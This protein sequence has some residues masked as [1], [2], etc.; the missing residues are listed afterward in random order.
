MC[1][2]TWYDVGCVLVAAVQTIDTCQAMFLPVGASA[3]LLIMFLF[4]DSLQMI[5]A[6]F[7]ASKSAGHFYRF[8]F[9][10][11]ASIKYVALHEATWCMVVWR[12]QDIYAKIAVSCGTSCASAVSAPLW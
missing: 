8:F 7:T 2:C 10:E 5:F 3:S 4:F 12:T 9:T 6:I 11:A 1:V